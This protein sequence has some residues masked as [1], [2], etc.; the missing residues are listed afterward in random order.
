FIFGDSLVDYGNNNYILSTYAKANFPPCGRDFPSG[1]TG[2]FSNGNLIPD[3]ITSYLNLPLVQPFL[4]PTKNI[5][6]GVN[7]GSAGCGLFNTTGNTFVSFQ[8]YPRP[9]YLQVQNFI[10]DKHTLISQIGLNATLNIINKSMFYITY[11]SND[12]A[13]NYY[14]PGSSLPSQ[15]TILEFIDILM[16][17]YDTQIRV[18][19]QEGARKI[20]I[21]SLFPLGCSTLFL[22]RYNVTQP[23]QCVDLFNKAATQF[24]CKLNLVL[25]YLRLNLPGLNILY[26]DSYTI[27]LDIVQNPQSYGFTIPNVGC[28]NFIGPNENTL[29]T[30]CLPLAPSCLDPRKYVYWDQV[31]PTSKTY[32]IL[33][34]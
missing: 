25:S 26:A 32:N 9:I 24:N 10:E 5:Q 6:Q 29:V 22:I 19:Y 2:R 28:C 15:Y 30:E 27:P 11:G 23:S 17:L 14:E 20:V 34:N 33:A 31:H 12:I 4:S 21:A 7:Y 1:A 3:L 18:L 16:Q 8:N 13:N